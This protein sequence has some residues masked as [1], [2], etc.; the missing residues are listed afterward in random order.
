MPGA[1]RQPVQGRSIETFRRIEAATQHLLAAGL[2]IDEI[3]T[4]MIAR[5][6][7]LSIG[8]LYR[9]FP[10]KQSIIDAIALQRLHDFEEQIANIVLGGA[11]FE[12]AEAL[13]CYV[14]DF[15]ARFMDEHP[16]FKTIVYGGGHLSHAVRQRHFTYAAKSAIL[17]RNYATQRFGVPGTPKFA[18]RWRM[19]GEIA[20]PL[21]GFAMNQNST[22]AR[23]AIMLETKTL[24]CKY[25]FG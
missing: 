5:Q 19:I 15:F 12:S 4:P 23:E 21:I 22:E 1:R 16:D 13:I 17:V 14:I 6:A 3:T 25:I 7:G 24:I 8:G 2:G 9:F 20:G 18:L 10:D 11:A